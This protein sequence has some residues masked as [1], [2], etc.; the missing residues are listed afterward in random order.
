MR[1]CVCVPSRLLI[2]SGVIWHDVDPIRLVKQVIQ[3]YMA[4][5]VVIVNGRDLGIGTCRTY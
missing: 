4:T 1:L 3:L 2:T 5:V